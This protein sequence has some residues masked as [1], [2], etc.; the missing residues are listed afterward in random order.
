MN[1]ITTTD[2]GNPMNLKTVISMT[3]GFSMLD[4][5]LLIW[6][7]SLFE[8]NFE[9]KEAT[10]LL[11][12]GTRTTGKV[13]SSTRQR[14]AGDENHRAYTMYETSFTVPYGDNTTVT[15]TTSESGEPPDPLHHLEA[16]DE[17]EAIYTGNTARQV[18]ATAARLATVEAAAHPE[19]DGALA[20][21]IFFVIYFGVLALTLCK[22][23]PHSS[24]LC[25]RV[26][27]GTFLTPSSPSCLF[28]RARCAYCTH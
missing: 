25:V 17:F 21:V 28:L 12:T 13:T 11:V 4:V 24:V 2:S 20:Y 19:K 15:I 3:I 8:K 27:A 9:A 18:K 5:F 16:G 1:N 6:P 14:F 23:L 26:L 22:S 10:H 7:C